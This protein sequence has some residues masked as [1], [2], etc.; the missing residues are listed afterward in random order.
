MSNKEIISVFKTVQKLL[1]LHDANP[2]KVRG[3]G[4][5]IFNLEKLEEPIETATTAT[6][7]EA[8]LKKGMLSKI[9]S[10][11]GT[12]TFDDFDEYRALT[13]D[14]VF[15]MLNVKGVGPKKIRT[16]WKDL[17]IDTVAKLYQACLDGQI[18]DVKGFGE[19][20]QAS[21]IE[22]LEFSM[23]NETTFRYADALAISDNILSILNKELNTDAVPVAQLAM[24]SNVV[25]TLTY[26]TTSLATDLELPFL[27]LDPK[28]SGPKTIRGTI[29]EVGIAFELIQVN[30]SEFD[31]KVIEYSSS[32]YHLGTP[33]PLGLNIYSALQK[34]TQSPKA[35]YNSIGYHEIP[36]PSREGIIEDL[37]KLD[38]PEPKLLENGD[39]LGIL[40]NHTTFSD[41]KHTLKEMADACKD[42][43]HQYVGITDHSVSAFY[44]KG[45]E[46]ERVLK[47]QKEIDELNA[48]YG[49]SFKIFKGM[50]SDILNDGSLDY[51]EDI[52]KTFDFIIA[53]V[54][55]NL[56]M[57]LDKATDRI[58]KAVENPYTT[59][60]GHP[61]GRLL[62]SRAGYPIDH[63]KIIDACAANGVTIEIN[64]SPWRLDIDW[65]WVPYCIEKG[66]MLSINPDAHDIRGYDDMQFGV[67][68]G[69]KG[70][71]TAEMT[72]NTR[73][74]K[75]LE[76]LF[77]KKKT[78]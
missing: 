75:E 18:A 53:S 41:G 2:F 6:L 17:E 67:L 50:E 69:R 47:Q 73:S 42:L 31:S 78:K 37:Y 26:V 46:V 65:T 62:A 59:M 55:S 32:E 70:G 1:E 60:L 15:D 10:F 44:A 49:D 48:G 39:L 19:K 9:E 16:L 54:H 23:K 63:Q 8:G 29:K 22:T 27:D 13:P 43:G 38:K 21:L 30:E 5:A 68:A 64:A 72:V 3:Y 25:D 34:S 71:L 56:K 35:F 12:G 66:V 74:R 40:H 20:T 51:E 14:G 57:D 76:K 28:Q 7:E 52:L 45:L 11:V 33:T 77:S 61:T 4:S 36:A 58:I 24:H